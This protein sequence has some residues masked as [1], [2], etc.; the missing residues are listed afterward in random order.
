M[1][2]LIC[3]LEHHIVINI[4]QYERENKQSHRKN[5]DLYHAHERKIY[6]E[7]S[8]RSRNCTKKRR[9]SPLQHAVIMVVS[10]M[11]VLDW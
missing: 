2:N 5:K 10:V 6:M 1:Q 3:I 7:R 4:V 8:S 11:E 9:H